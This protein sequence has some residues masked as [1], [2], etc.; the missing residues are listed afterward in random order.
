MIAALTSDGTRTSK[1]RQFRFCCKAQAKPHPRKIRTREGEARIMTL[2][3]SGDPYRWP[4]N[5]YALARAAARAPTTASRWFRERRGLP[6]AAALRSRNHQRAAP[7]TQAPCWFKQ[8]Q[9]HDYSSRKSRCSHPRTGRHCSA[10]QNFLPT[11]PRRS[12]RCRARRAALPRRGARRPPPA[13]PRA[14]PP[15]PSPRR[16]RS[17]PTGRRRR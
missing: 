12:R 15:S 16:L 6:L 14:P 4:P 2:L 13:D 5:M 9:P 3:V 7:T 8:N 10:T 17:S 1:S 11:R